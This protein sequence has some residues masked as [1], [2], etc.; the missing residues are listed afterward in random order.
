MPFFSDVRLYPV[1]PLLLAVCLSPVAW[2]HWA[3][4]Q[5]KTTLKKTTEKIENRNKQ[6]RIFRILKPGSIPVGAV[7]AGADVDARPA[8]RRP[9]R[10][11]PGQHTQQP[12]LVHPELEHPPS[13]VADHERHCGAS[14]ER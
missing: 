7:P 11:L 9:E 2:G 1:L 8:L 3:Y 13:R 10:E 4:K 6:K 5:T 14:Y 12:V